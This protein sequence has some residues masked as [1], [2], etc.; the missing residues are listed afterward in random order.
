MRPPS[1]D[2]RVRMLTGG[3]LERIPFAEVVRSVYRE[4][5]TA[6][7]LVSRS[8][9][10][11]TFSFDRG[12]ILFASSNREAQ[13]VGELL[14]TFGLADENLL[15]SAFEKAL[16]EPG[17]GLARALTESGAVPGYVAE[18]AVRALS[19]RLF[20]DTLKWTSGVFTVTPLDAAPEV[21]AKMDRPTGGMLLEAL[22]RIPAPASQLN[23]PLDPGSRPIFAPDLLLRYQAILVSAE[24]AEVLG[25]VDGAMT[26]E[27]IHR[28]QRI[29]A[30]LAAT[31]LVQLVAQ[32]RPIEKSGVAEGLL[33]MNVEI[34]GAQPPARVAEQQELQREVVWNT[35][36]RLD[37]ATHYD[38][39]GVEPE[40]PPEV[41][42]KALHERAR[43]FHPDH[44]LKSHLGDAR[45]ALESAVRPHPDRRARVPQSRGPDGIRPDAR[46]ERGHHRA[47]G[48]RAD[49]GGP[50]GDRPQELHAREGAVRGGGLLPGVRDD[51]PGRRVRSRP[52]GVL[53][54]PR[55][56]PAQEPEV[57]AARHGDD[58]ARRQVHP[59]ERRALVGAGGGLP[60][61]AERAGAREGPERGHAARPGEPPGPVRAL[62]DLGQGGPVTNGLPQL[63]GTGLGLSAAAGLNSYAVLLVYGAMARFFPEDYPG[64]IARLLA[65]TPALGVAAVLFFM[66]FFADKIPGLDH[67]WHLLHSFV[68]PVVGALVALAAVQPEGSAVLDVVAAGSGGTVALV[69]HLVKSAT[70]L[71]STA[72]TAGIA[73]VAL[74]LAEDIL[75]FLQSLVSI[76]LPFVALVVVAAIGLTLR[77]HV[78]RMA[79]FLDLFGR[80]RPRREAPP[81]A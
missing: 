48:H 19:E 57:G 25:K 72:L 16:N 76:F 20:F 3:S 71:T 4:R 49:H 55:E 13:L 53:G 28:D 14:R 54:A 21:P 52:E 42:V 56:N 9:E 15:L 75:A 39:L 37:W 40:D 41:L 1:S 38:L 74:S 45:D 44:H 69:S 80:R 60:A 23:S 59:G 70:R 17:S 22:R 77:P 12:Q 64:A 34:A 31:G 18:A 29:V 65:S 24:E 73:N 32:G 11:R 10:E 30:R 5:T 43:L 68:R 27:Q 50:E 61:R 6:K 81:T 58:A 35:Y 47:A 79:R 2:S 8:G 78:P 7:L 67:F 26:V 33:F 51:T 36:R 46:G 63:F 66:E 62:R